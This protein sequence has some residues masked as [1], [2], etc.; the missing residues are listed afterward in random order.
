MKLAVYGTL[1][2]GSDRL[3]HIADTALVFPGH[4]RF[5]AM[6]RDESGEGTIVEIH[7]VDSE[8]LAAYDR[9][10]GVAAGV[11]QRTLMK[12]TMADGTTLEAWVYLAGEK[13]L[14]QSASFI[15]I[16]GGDWFER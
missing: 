2:N 4:R 1:R 11:Y 6:I 10:E 8:T 7:E 16:S 12:V 15:A 13:L 9:Y 5:P 14:A 3:G